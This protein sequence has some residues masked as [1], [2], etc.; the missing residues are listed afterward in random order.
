MATGVAR[1]SRM[2]DVASLVLVVGGAVCY[3]WAY[4]GM[5]ALRVAVH[6]PNAAIFAGYVRFVRLTQLSILG[7][8][9]IGLG[10]VVGVGA[11][12]HARRVRA[13]I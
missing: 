1:S 10:V 7:L 13:P 12:I 11:A 5:R 3:V 6:D 9:M 2:I 4:A 8:I